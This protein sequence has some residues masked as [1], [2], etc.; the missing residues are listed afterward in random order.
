MKSGD[1]REWF[2][3]DYNQENL[4]SIRKAGFEEDSS[5]VQSSSEY[6]ES[7]DDEDCVERKADQITEESMQRFQRDDSSD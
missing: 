6:S 3:S 5:M 2:W 1:R 7:E 4:I